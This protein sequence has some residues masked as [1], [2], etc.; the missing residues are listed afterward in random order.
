MERTKKRDARA[1]LLL[2]LIN[3]CFFDVLATAAAAVAKAS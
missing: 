3:H 1:K 2:C